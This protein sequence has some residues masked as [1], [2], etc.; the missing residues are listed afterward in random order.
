MNIDAPATFTSEVTLEGDVFTPCNVT[1]LTLNLWKK[2]G[3]ARH[4]VAEVGYGFHI[5][6]SN[7]LEFVKYTKFDT[8]NSTIKSVA[9][10]GSSNANN[11]DTTPY[12]LFD[13]ISN[14]S[15]FDTSN[16]SR[17]AVTPSNVTMFG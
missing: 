2:E 15:Y 10:F 17:S 11:T 6:S 4:T 16:P 8:S 5:N 14:I 12:I 7:H 9:N 1:G 13:S 3:F